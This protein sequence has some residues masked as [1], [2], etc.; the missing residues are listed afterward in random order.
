MATHDSVSGNG[1]WYDEHYW[2]FDKDGPVELFVTERINKIQES[3]LPKDFGVMN[4]GGFSLENLTYA[5]P[6]WGSDDGHC[7][8]SGGSIQIKFALKDHQLFVVSQS[9]NRN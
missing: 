9:Y 7:C 2:A 4:G 5:T 1:N 6:V 8:P 3:L